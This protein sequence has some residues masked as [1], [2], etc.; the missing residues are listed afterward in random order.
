[1]KKSDLAP[2]VLTEFERLQTYASGK[3]QDA[4]ARGRLPRVNT[5]YRACFEEIQPIPCVDCGE[6]SQCYDHRDYLEPLSVDP[7]CGPCNYRRGLATNT[8]TDHPEYWAK[9]EGVL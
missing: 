8:F 1:M 7:V 9:F 5:R 6:Q 4:I 2:V 3:V